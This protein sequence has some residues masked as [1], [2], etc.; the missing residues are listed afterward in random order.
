MIRA[1][2]ENAILTRLCGRWGL[3]LSVSCLLAAAMSAIAGT[4]VDNLTG[5]HKSWWE[6][7]TGIAYLVANKAHGVC[8]ADRRETAGFELAAASPS[9]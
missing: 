7:D 3:R 9:G 1:E 2:S 8:G 4:I 6:C 5:T